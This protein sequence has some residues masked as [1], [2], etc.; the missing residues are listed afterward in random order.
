M[1]KFWREPFGFKKPHSLKQRLLLA[2]LLFTGFWLAFPSRLFH[3][4]HSTVLLDH[5]GELLSARIATDGQ[6]RFPEADSIPLNLRQAI[7]QFEDAYFYWHPGVNPVSMLRALW[8]NLRA[9]HTVSGGSTISMQVIRLSRQGQQRTYL[10]KL[11]EMYMALRLEFSYTKDEIMAMYIS[12]AP[13]GGNVVGAEAASWRYFHRPLH[14]L[15]WAEASTLA[16]LPNAPSLM[17]PGR[18]RE[19]LRTKRDRLLQ[20]LMANEIID[21]TTY[22]L[23]LMEPLPDEP[24]P[25]PGD[26][27]HL[28]DFACL[29]GKEGLRVRCSVDGELQRALAGKLDRYVKLLAQNEVHNACALIVSLETGEVKAYVGNA[30]VPGTRSPY[31]DIIHAPRSSGSILKPF[32]YGVAVEE[33]MIH[34]ASMLRDVP[35]TIGTFSPE[36]FDNEFE[37]VVPAGE[38]LARSLNIPATLLLRD[39]GIAPFHEDLGKLGFTTVTRPAGNYGLTLI[40]GGAEACLWDLARAYTHQAMALRN[41]TGMTA[42]STGLKLWPGES[43]PAPQKTIDA[44]AWWLISEALTDV[45]RPDLNK[46]WKHFSSSRKIAWKTGTSHGFRDAWAVGYDGGYLV[47]VWIGNADGEGRPGL[48]GTST[49]AP[50]M[51]EAF[52][53]LPRSPWFLKPEGHLRY[54]DL[55]AVTGMAPSPFCPVKKA[56][57]PMNARAPGGFVCTAHQHILLNEQGERVYHDCA[58]GQPRDTT[59]F[60]LDPVAGYFYKQKHANY[61]PLPAFASE[62]EQGTEE[63]LAIIYPAQG[64]DIILPRDFD[65]QFERLQFRAAHTQPQATLFWHLDESYI[66]STKG[67]HQLITDVPIGLH[68]LLVMDERGNKVSCR[69]R[70]FRG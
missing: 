40:L 24:Q 33:G 5:R 46:D 19:A 51:F 65:G 47:A 66:G 35:V 57:A 23:A 45:Q 42:D 22:S 44:G 3:E 64:T 43:F 69:F 61:K 10:E 39:Y 62:C 6:W 30:T 52:Q 55:C 12:H 48:T 31:V 59:W 28:L 4:P 38:A 54:T 15:S 9:G 70:L 8:Q 37:G 41:A 50:L 25:L 56:E 20:K 18:N 26:A 1:H 2:A 11:L 7:L 14:R 36:N 17:H 49:A 53:L 29:S 68:T 58:T 63:T 60:S 32:L 21:S 27:F 67:S 13:Y 34:T 16:V